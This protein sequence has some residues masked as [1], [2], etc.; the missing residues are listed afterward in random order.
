MEAHMVTLLINPKDRDAFVEEMIEHARIS[1]ET[2][3]GCLRYDVLHDPRD[4]G[5][6]FTYE[7]FADHESF[8]A[9]VKAPHNDEWL[10]K[11]KDWHP[12]D[13][14]QPGRYETLYPLDSQWRELIGAK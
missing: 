6:V 3:A 13:W 4:P 8:E 10:E 11:I 5:R 12:A 7:V 14:I 1:V 9:H 2:E